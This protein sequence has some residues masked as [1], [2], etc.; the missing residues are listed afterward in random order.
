[1]QEEIDLIKELH[2][3]QDDPNEWSEE[4]VPIEV[5]PGRTSVVSFRLPT[6]ELDALEEAAAAAGESIS[7]YVRKA[8]VLRLRDA[9]LNGANAV[10]STGTQF[11]QHAAWDRW[12]TAQ[13]TIEQHTYEE[14][15]RLVS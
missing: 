6:R 14:K 15:L 7:E 3:H 2:E 8:V 4:A 10:I 9:A 11:T 5:R 13:A 12:N 1:M